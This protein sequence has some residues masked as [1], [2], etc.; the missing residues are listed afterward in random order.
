MSEQDLATIYD[1]LFL[2]FSPVAKLFQTMSAIDVGAHG[3]VA[4][5]YGEIGER[6]TDQFKADMQR[7]LL[8]RKPGSD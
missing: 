8:G 4:N 1:E 2:S 6:L 3:P 5:Y 7:L